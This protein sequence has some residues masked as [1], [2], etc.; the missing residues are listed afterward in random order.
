MNGPGP[1]DQPCMQALE[2]RRVT[3]AYPDDLDPAWIP[4]QPEFSYMADGLSLLMPYAEPLFI[5]AVRSAF[6][7]IDEPLRERTE[8]YIRQEVGHYR[9]HERFNSMIRGRH[10]GVARIE[11]WMK[12]C[13]D[14]ITRTR[15]QRFRLAFA[16]GGEIMSFLLARWTDRHAGDLFR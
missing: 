10:P 2:Q 1:A 7:Q 9:E 12:R 16:S 8:S 6:D 13:A 3:F 11:R 15:S 4:S 14:W 5:K